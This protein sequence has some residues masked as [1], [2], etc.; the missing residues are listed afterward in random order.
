MERRLKRYYNSTYDKEKKLKIK[1]NSF[2]KWLSV[3]PFIV[4][5]YKLFYFFTLHD[6]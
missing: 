5:I 2:E 1:K 6:Y 3:K 4:M